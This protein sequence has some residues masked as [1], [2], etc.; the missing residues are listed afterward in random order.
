M[1][2]MFYGADVF[3]GD[4]SRSMGC[5]VRSMTQMFFVAFHWDK[6]ARRCSSLQWRRATLVRCSRQ[7]Y[8]RDVRSRRS[9]TPT[10]GPNPNP[11][12]GQV[13]AAAAR[14]AARPAAAR[15]RLRRRH[16]LRLRGGARPLPAGCDAALLPRGRRGGARRA[17]PLRPGLAQGQAAP[18]TRQAMGGAPPLAPRA[19]RRHDGPRAVLAAPPRARPPAVGGGPARRARLPPHPPAAAPPRAAPQA[20]GPAAELRAHDAAPRQV[21]RAVRAPLRRA[22]R[23]A[24]G[25]A[26]GRSLRQDTGDDARQG[27]AERV[28]RHRGPPR[29]AQGAEPRRPLH[30]VLL[31]RRDRAQG[32]RA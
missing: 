7:E 15:R 22:P 14:R 17:A 8:E 5:V 18:P 20:R 26:R 28:P 9:L 4:A 11:T 30:P 27:A 19:K 6:C 2:E 1:D 10:P 12:P 13:R 31:P 24:A 32:V 3:N 25:G 21:R 23:R 16:P 29:A